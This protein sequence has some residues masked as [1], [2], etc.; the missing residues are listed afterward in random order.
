MTGSA[1]RIGVLGPLVLEYN[2][3]PVELPGGRPR[4]LLAVLLGADG[5]LSR[6]RLIDELWGERPPAS[7]VSM[8][9]VY[10]S[11]LRALLG[12]VLV[13]GPAG[14]ALVP[15][16]FELDARE[17]DA[18][19][20]QAR[21]DVE[22]SGSLLSGAL[23]LFRGEPLCDVACEG[24]VA[25][26]RRVLEDKRWQVM[27]ARFDVLLDAGADGGLLSELERLA[28][29][30]PLDERLVGQ[31]MLALYRAGRQAD[32][33]DAY[34]R[35]RA[36][37]AEELG[38]DPGPVLQSRH[39]QILEHA[40][41]LAAPDRAAGLV[42]ASD[43][44]ALGLPALATATIGREDALEDVL[45]LLGRQ[46]V[47]IVTL[48]GPGGVGKTRLAL[49]AAHAS[50]PSCAEGA[51]WIELAGVAHADEVPST[52]ARGLGVTPAGSE[53]SEHALC[54]YL[55]AKQLLL[56]LDNFEHM[57]DSARLVA[58]LHRSCP[59][60]IVLVTSREA[61]DLSAEHRYVVA[62][63]RL[64]AR[65][66]MLTVEDVET[67]PSTA[68]F[69][70]AARRRDHRFSLEP[71]DVPAVA[72][73]C[74]RLEGLPLAIELAA[75]R[76]STIDLEQLAIELDTELDNLGTGP[77]DAA[78]RHR[79]LE[80]AIQWSFKL[81]DP[82]LQTVF[83]RF[84]VFAG[85]ATLTAAQTITGAR[86]DGLDALVA[87]SMIERRTEPGDGTR[88]V[89][90]DTLRH[91]AQR[92][93][94]R[95]PAEAELRRCHLEHYL[96]VAEEADAQLATRHTPRALSVFDREIENL[97]AAREWALQHEPNLGLRLTGRLG[98]YWGIRRN[99]GALGW[100]EA[101]LSAAGDHAPLLDRARTEHRR[102][103]LLSLLH[104]P[105][106]A[107]A[108][109]NVALSL[110][111]EAD[112]H[113]GI[114]N[115]LCSLALDTGALTGDLEQERRYAQSAVQYAKIG[116]DERVLA[117]ALSELAE[118]AEGD[119][120]LPLLEQAAV[121][122][123]RLGNE[124]GL[125]KLYSN[126]A[127]VALTEGRVEEANELLER[128][129]EVPWTRDD[130]WRLA[131]VLGNLGL[132][133]L[134]AGEPR[135]ARAP[136]ADALRH[137]STHGFDDDIG[138]SL[139]GLAAIAAIEGDLDVAAR[140]R[141]AVRTAGYP[142]GEFDRQIDQRLIRDYMIAAQE[143]L[144]SAKWIL[145]EEIGAAWTPAAAAAYALAWACADVG[146]QGELVAGY[147]H[148]AGGRGDGPPRG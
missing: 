43:P 13:S 142:P 42:R 3:Q 38:L 76:T 51:C 81:L 114:A 131:G 83:T 57:I 37:L 91:F 135:A 79:T 16:R 68:M 105:E 10:L 132:A 80:A 146:V 100:C 75:A 17:F 93:L 28:R 116:G 139:A 89:M 31:L 47:R 145:G 64:P 123:T 148:A 115:S 109:A 53:T 117:L 39:Q 19:I 23:E 95:Q 101:A 147:A 50:A 12:E 124:R 86:I 69:L 78:A 102:A 6:D 26:W 7:A 103:R 66:E 36:R 127:Y 4:A 29:E 88:L 70:A 99:P 90:L 126:A 92:Q 133:R 30:H 119:D 8:L 40:P 137:F 71:A 61:L 87:K 128:A 141:G 25:E 49:L 118:A 73:I 15:D 35:V 129:L 27:L 18:L 125:T 22:R 65:G 33:L 110:Y 98:S 21:V 63:L 143:R 52:I 113:A 96:D 14:Y 9:H 41:S 24:S 106:A 122:L 32:A 56:V 58:E 112:D 59:R 2:G 94:A 45:S 48:V 44:A 34:R 11:K 111:R 46:E 74:T 84:A 67:T 82:D 107:I 120:R 54:R 121:V 97:H 140:L 130:P 104:R 134:F 77:R 62:P 1:L 138:E 108:A 20:E 5:P 136:F 55:A 72:R 60:L 85:G 144:G